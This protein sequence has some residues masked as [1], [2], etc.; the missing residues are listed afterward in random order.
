M[1][2]HGSSQWR[3]PSSWWSWQ[4]KL[5]WSWP[6]PW[7]PA[8]APAA[9]QWL[10]QELQRLRLLW[11]RDVGM[12]RIITGIFNIKYKDFPETNASGQIGSD[13][14]GKQIQYSVYLVWFSCQTSHVPQDSL[15]FNK[16]HFNLLPSAPCIFFFCEGTNMISHSMFLEAGFAFVSVRKVKGGKKSFQKHFSQPT[17]PRTKTAVNWS[18]FHFLITFS[19]GTMARPLPNLGHSRPLTFF[20]RQLPS[21]QP[22]TTDPGSLRKCDGEMWQTHLFCLLGWVYTS[23]QIPGRLLMPW[24]W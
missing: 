7:P 5:C 2:R 13:I 11:L 23:W 24:R 3:Q 8:S 10:K 1:P 4:L 18:R 9:T 20:P 6:R 21:P 16:Y 14:S 15:C 17:R 22:P 12:I 19:W